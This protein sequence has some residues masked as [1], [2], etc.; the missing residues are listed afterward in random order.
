M[1]ASLVSDDG[2]VDPSGPEVGTTALDPVSPLS[3]DLDF[4]PL[5]QG[6]DLRILLSRT[7][8]YGCVFLDERKYVLRFII[9]GTGFHCGR[10]NR[11]SVCRGPHQTNCGT[12]RT[13]HQKRG[14]E[15]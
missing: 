3:Q 7:C 9:L 15:N 1:R 6:G 4:S 5:I 10:N 2:M 14:S 8:I 11:T 13:T 12:Y